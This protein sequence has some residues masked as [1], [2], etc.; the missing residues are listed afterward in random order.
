MPSE[1]RG[2]SRNGL[3][4]PSLPCNRRASRTK[5]GS[6]P[7]RDRKTGCAAAR[8]PIEG[9]RRWRTPLSRVRSQNGLVICY[10]ERSQGRGRFISCQVSVR[11]AARGALAVLLAI[12]SWAPA[13]G[14]TRRRPSKGDRDSAPPKEVTAADFVKKSDYCPPIQIRAGTATMTVYERGHE[15]ETALCPLSRLDQPDRAG[16]LDGRRIP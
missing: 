11:P 5:E 10:R 7:L 8:G 15:N 1:G 16:M 9:L 4:E 6:R 2:R 14:S 13:P 3:R 12:W